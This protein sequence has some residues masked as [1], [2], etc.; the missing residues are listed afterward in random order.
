VLNGGAPLKDGEQPMTGEEMAIAVA[1]VRNKA[2][3]FDRIAY[4]ANTLAK[5]V[6]ELETELAQYKASK[7]GN[8]DGNGRPPAPEEQDPMAILDKL[9]RER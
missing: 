2:A 3:G 4:R 8:G 7:P 6:K 9:G 5:R 1:A